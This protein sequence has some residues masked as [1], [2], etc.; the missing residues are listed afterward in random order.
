MPEYRAPLPERVACITLT[1]A[2]LESARRLRTGL[3][4]RVDLYA[5]ARAVDGANDYQRFDRV[6]TLLPSLWAEHDGLVLCFALGAAVRLIAP[7][8]RDKRVDPAVVVIDDAARFAISVVSGHL[9]G[10][11][12]LAEVC[13]GVLGAT[14]VITTATDARGTLAVDLL[15]REFGWQLDPCSQLTPVTAA[16][17]TGAPVAIMQ[18]A[19]ETDWLPPG[20]VLPVGVMSVSDLAAVDA[21]AYAGGVLITDRLADVLPAGMPWVVYRPRSLVVG[22]GCRRGVPCASLDA[23][24][25]EAL[26]A[27]TLSPLSLAAIATASLKRDEPALQELARRYGV[28]LVTFPEEELAR[29]A[30]PMPSERVRTL[31]GTPSV[32]EAAALLASAGGE[33]IV[34]KRKGEAC[35]VAVA[36]KSWSAGSG[37][38]DMSGAQPVAGGAL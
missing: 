34:R 5:S 31:V 4:M 18:E 8:L 15:G 3:P 1:R 16:L 2:G 38:S 17:A 10:A 27:N 20:E 30:T 35:T 33:L 23:L 6:G 11:N 7:L 28:P 19:G 26:A 13:A 12:A 9:G 32:S 37:N 36:R 14:A 29:V 24:V 22:M 21:N 25:R